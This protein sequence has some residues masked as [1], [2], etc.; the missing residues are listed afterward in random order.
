MTSF[1][2][3]TLVKATAGR[4]AALSRCTRPEYTHDQTI[5]Y[6]PILYTLY[7]RVFYILE[8]IL[9]HIKIGLGLRLG[10]TLT[11]TLTPHSGLGRFIPRGIIYCY[12]GIELRY[13]LDNSGL[14]C[15]VLETAMFVCVNG[16]LVA[17]R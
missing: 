6:T 9:Y 15:N 8:T 2:I 13:S 7:T 16:T 10:P 5:C 11:P 12:I 4:G 17:S 3:Q 14:R 1:Q